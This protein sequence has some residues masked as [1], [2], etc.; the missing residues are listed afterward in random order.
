MTPKNPYIEHSSSFLNDSRNESSI[1]LD[2]INHKLAASTYRLTAR[3][4][5]E[6]YN[7]QAEVQNQELLNSYK[8][9]LAR[10]VSGQITQK[11]EKHLL[12]AQVDNLVVVMTYE[13]VQEIQYALQSLMATVG[14]RIRVM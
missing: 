14:H 13:E 4:P 5:V 10:E 3:I 1:L 11:I 9:Q 6:V 2:K 7:T 12:S 8:E